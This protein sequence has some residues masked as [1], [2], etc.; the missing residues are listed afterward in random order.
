MRDELL[1][2]SQENNI[3]VSTDENF[4]VMIG[5]LSMERVLINHQ[6]KKSI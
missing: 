6:Q 4:I 5:S 2:F 1:F 3:Q